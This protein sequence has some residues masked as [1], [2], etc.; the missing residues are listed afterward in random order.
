MESMTMRVSP[1]VIQALL[2][3]WMVAVGVDYIT[4]TS[5]VYGLIGVIVATCC[6]WVRQVMWKKS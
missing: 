3:F 1:R 5:P 6:L 2:I 4:G